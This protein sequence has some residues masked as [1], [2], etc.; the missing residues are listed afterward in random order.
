MKTK[1]V[2]LQKEMQKLKSRE[3]GDRKNASWVLGDSKD[4]RVVEPLIQALKIE[5][6]RFVRKNIVTALAK[7]G[8]SRWWSR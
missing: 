5:K 4:R 2:N 6:D 7:I 8:D 1:T 3:I